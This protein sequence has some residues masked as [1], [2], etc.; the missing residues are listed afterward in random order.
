MAKQ[1]FFSRIFTGGKEKRNMMFSSFWGGFAPPE[2]KSE[3]MLRSLKG[4]VYSCVT[5]ITEEVANINYKLL[6]MENGDFIEQEESP[7]LDLLYRVNPF[8]TKPEFLKLHQSYME[9]SGESFWFLERGKENP[10][11]NDPI[12]ELWL[13]RPDWID[14]VPD[15]NTFIKGYTYRMAGKN[16][17]FK[18]FEIITFKYPNPLNPYRGMSPVQAAALAIDTE[19]YSSEWNRNFFYNSARPDAV[20]KTKDVLGEDSYKRLQ[21]Q[22]EAN[23]G[24]IKN[25]QRIAILEQGLEY[26]QMSLSQKD[27]DFMLQKGMTRDEI[28]GVWRVPKTVLGITEDVTVSNAEATNY[29]F[30]SRVIKPKM[31]ALVDNLNEYLVPLYGDNL[32]MDF[33]DPTPENREKKIQEYVNG[34]NKWLTINEIRNAEGLPP[35][36]G[37]DAIYQT[38]ANMPVGQVENYPTE[39]QEPET[40][41]SLVFKAPPAKDYKQQKKNK[42]FRKRLLAGNKRRKNIESMRRKIEMII[43]A[44]KEKEIKDETE[45]K[46]TAGL[47]MELAKTEIE[48]DF[49]NAENEKKNQTILNLEKEKEEAE[50]MASE[51]LG[52]SEK[53][54]QKDTTNKS[55]DSGKEI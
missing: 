49:L 45:K 31:Q 5:A 6:K 25:A 26:Q 13:L 51:A 16:L 27:M 29:V 46:E 38:M 55:G 11:P 40:P 22:W 42:I 8:Q 1:N 52:L 35:V 23:Y 36:S 41:K 44:K 33:D 28:L 30:G 2:P 21:S 10:K 47:I 18:P 14:V 50:K 53:D 9:L 20:L 48:R 43:D 24:G 34:F 3:D 4:W 7:L 32:W 37:G 19:R 54:G 15:E 12:K 39:E 17:S